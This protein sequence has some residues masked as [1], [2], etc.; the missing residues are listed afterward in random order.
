MVRVTSP[1]GIGINPPRPEQVENRPGFFDTLIA[2]GTLE[3]DVAAFTRMMTQPVY[4][5]DPSFNM[6]ERLAKSPYRL[7]YPEAL[8]RA[9]SLE[10]FEAIEARIKTE[11]DAR[12]TLAAAGTGG[13]VAAIGA[14]LLSPTMAIP[15]VGPARGAKGV[16]QAFALAAGAS[17]A[18][19][20]AL[21]LGSETRTAE[22][23][24]IGVAAGTVVGGLLGSAAAYLAPGARA[25][26]V[27]E[28]SATR[29]V[30]EVSYLGPAGSG[31]VPPRLQSPDAAVEV[32]SE[33]YN[34][35][36]ARMRESLEDY[37]DTGDLTPDEVYAELT[38]NGALADEWAAVGVRNGEDLVAY[39]RNPESFT[40]DVEQV[41]ANLEA[42]K[43]AFDPARVQD[44]RFTSQILDDSE[45]AITALRGV[46]ARI[47]QH[48]ESARFFRDLSADELPENIFRR[49]RAEAEQAAFADEALAELEQAL[50]T[51]E[52]L[53]SILRGVD[54]LGDLE[55]R[56]LVAE[57]DEYDPGELA[58]LLVEGGD[59][60]AGVRALVEDILE[61]N[62]DIFDRRARPAAEARV[63]EANEA[64]TLR[65]EGVYAT[66]SIED[67]SI[68][69]AETR[70]VTRQNLAARDP[71]TGWIN[72]QLARLNPVTRVI[73]QTTSN[74]GAVAMARLS[75]A[76]LKLSANAD[77]I[78]HAPEG[79]VEARAFS[80]QAVIAQFVQEYD[81]AYSRHV[82]GDIADPEVYQSAVRAQIA[83]GLGRLPEGKMSPEEFGELV[84]TLGST[85]ETST[86]PNVTKA[87]AAQK[88]VFDY[89]KTV[90]EEAYQRRLELDPEAS[91]LFD[92]EGNLG[93]DVFNYIHQVY[94]TQKIERGSG[95]FKDDI[96]RHSQSLSEE[97]FRKS[98]ARWKAQDD[99]MAAQQ[100]ELRM[101]RAERADYAD[102]LAERLDEI[103]GEPIVMAHR[104][105]E[106]ALQ[107]QI[108]EADDT[109]RPFLEDEMIEL[110]RRRSP[111]LK[112][113]LAEARRTQEVFDR[114]MRIQGL[115]DEVR[116]G[117]LGAL[118]A[119]RNRAEDGFD[120]RW[121]ENGAVDLNLA[122]GEADFTEHALEQ[123]ELL[124][125]KMVGLGTRASGMEI[126]S[127]ARGPELSRVLN[128][129][130]AVKRK[131]LNMNPEHTIRRYGRQM[132]AD[133][134]MYRAFGS[135]NGAEIFADTA[136]EF[137]R[138]RTQAE[139][140]GVSGKEIERINAAQR[141]VEG[142]LRVSIQRLRHQRG[143]PDNPDGLMF[144]LGRAA[145]DLNVVRLMG[146][147]VL[148]SV[149]DVARPVMKSGLQRTFRRGWAP[150]VTNMEQVNATRQEARRLGIALD[151]ILHNRTQAVFEMM[152]D[153]TDRRTVA[154]RGLGYLAN[155]TGF[156]AGFDRWTAE[157]KYIASSVGISEI[158]DALR[159]T[160]G[161]A[162]GD[163]RKA[164]ELLA[165]L[166]IDEPTA[167]RIWE[168]FQ[169]EGGSTEF[170]GGFVLPN[171]EAW[172]DYRAMAAYRAALGK[173]VND[174]IVT[175]GL[176]RPSWV[177]ANVGARV[178][179]QFRSFTFSSTNRVIMAGL[180]ERDAAMA[181]GMI[182]SLA[183]GGLSYYLY[184]VSRGGDTLREA[185]E[186][187]P[188]QWADEA[189]SRSG[190]LGVFAEAQ[191]MAQAIPALRDYASFSDQGP[192]R[193]D[194]SGPLGNVIGP[195]FGLVQNISNILL[196]MDEPTQ[197]TLH[198]ARLITPYQN[199]YWFR[200]I[201]DHIEEGVGDVLGLPERRT[202]Q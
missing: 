149:P 126:L 11:E 173:Y 37:A 3:N 114:L 41:R 70:G 12:E 161:G 179:A 91:R 105:R 202:S 97:Q 189:I 154:E 117:E 141:S 181:Q 25:D 32:M 8:G 69:A 192:I 35:E 14:G 74:V 174:T 146:S 82:L 63:T 51:F 132:S 196:G 113:L 4:P 30:E 43:V 1:R 160:V 60:E 158:S 151:P 18:Q 80:H 17:G 13:F 136:E 86:D 84:Y 19:E 102:Q 197:S 115:A 88:K 140:R 31:E 29:R 198:Q 83:A 143:L 162:A 49:R 116:L 56:R 171:T 168:Q 142:D 28:V 50:P 122:R 156:V 62:R 2:A 200:R 57:L 193:R 153:G 150:F 93:P 99:E 137:R 54:G 138:L 6:Q 185:N 101:G 73:S 194:P 100:A 61:R 45:D 22:E 9:T 46:V 106:E 52:E 7:S 87:V 195:S 77:F 107:V 129:P 191:K 184:G 67:R 201:L 152:D 190:L 133:V 104:Q 72:Q 42:Q 124:Y 26:V 178:V 15:L 159:L 95:E 130:F 48:V 34:T 148:S 120:T 175:P 64:I 111:A 33:G 144:R 166:G 103:D 78:A 92:P 172:D 121:R 76:G 53:E 65:Q 147:V 27:S 167:H 176:D 5:E 16:A 89:Y 180:Q 47:S 38:E 118:T 96:A 112:T 40:P 170:D 134:E 164:Q 109:I 155:K 39:A 157:M 188:D 183:L 81:D 125:D 169:R 199:V 108:D 110:Q 98:W 20:A 94:D 119:R 44:T 75:D 23:A 135:V 71:V 21:F 68:G 10:E 187:N 58:G 163:T 90:A 139:A 59:V 145:L 165:A 128:L 66:R 79:T 186:F 55:V 177:D 36:V 182:F 131:W 24:A 127:G 85:G 123:A